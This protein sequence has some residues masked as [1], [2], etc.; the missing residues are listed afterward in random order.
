MS[1]SLFKTIFIRSFIAR[2]PVAGVLNCSSLGGAGLWRSHKTEEV[3][4]TPWLHRWT[5]YGWYCLAVKLSMLF[6]G[7]SLFLTC[8]YTFFHR[9]VACCRG[10]T[11]RNASLLAVDNLSCYKVVGANYLA[12]SHFGYIFYVLSMPIES[13]KDL[14]AYGRFLNGKRS[15]CFWGVRNS[16]GGA[17]WQAIFLTW[18]S[19]SPPLFPKTL[20]LVF[21]KALMRTND[22]AGR[23]SHKQ[24]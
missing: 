2:L 22:Y 8:F 5:S 21:L 16:L 17:K 13:T 19:D 24:K 15:W 7:N 1:L 20:T 10:S 14:C 4:C 23:S 9:A 18:R 12:F 6:I 3:L 11:R